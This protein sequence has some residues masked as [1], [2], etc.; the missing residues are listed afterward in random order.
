[1]MCILM[2]HMVCE[3]TFAVICLLFFV[4]FAFAVFYIINV[5][6][7]ALRHPRSIVLYIFQTLVGMECVCQG[8][9]GSG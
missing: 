4:G 8:A 7:P 2:A 1:M 9:C 3:Q 5:D 6:V